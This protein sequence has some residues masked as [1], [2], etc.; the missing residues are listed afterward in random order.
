MDVLFIFTS[1]LFFLWVIRDLFFWLSVWQQ[2]DYRQ[3]RFF[4]AIRKRPRKQPLPT[5]IF[6]FIKWFIFFAY[7]LVILNDSS[8]DI[9]Q[10]VIFGLYLVQSFFLLQ[11]IYLNHLRKPIITFRVTGIIAVTLATVLLLFA[12]PL[13]DRFFW[14]LFIDLLT[15]VI[16]AFYVL[17]SS[18][19]I[20][21]YNDSQ[22]EKAGQKIREHPDVL[23]IAVTG[24]VGKSL[25]KD[26]IAAILSRKFHVIKTEGK[27][28]NTIGVAQ[29]ILK[30]LDDK[31]QIFVAEISAYQK[32]EI[33]MLCELIKPQI[34]VLTNINSYYL[35]IFKTMDAI[36]K[37]NFE[38]VQS[39]PKQ[40]FCL[41]DGNSKNTWTLYKKSRKTKVLYRSSP[42][43]VMNTPVDN[44]IVASNIVH[45]QK[46]TTFSVKVK[47]IKFDLNL[48]RFHHIEALLPALYIASYLGMTE[49]EIKRQVALLK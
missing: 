48:K 2:N 17:V 7:G 36:T 46:R 15:P 44:E 21:I 33:G 12:I 18:F 37:T 27:D 3:N 13:V 26:Y 10:Y 43:N 8:L 22:I 39:L 42:N 23:V 34:G 24:S 14:L 11:E 28:N 30:K 29:T 5:T 19:P 1:S 41:Y 25:T 38:L 40:G 32:G 20:E 47:N 4:A 35:P 31:T 6:F 9:Y 45:K 49:Q 16:V